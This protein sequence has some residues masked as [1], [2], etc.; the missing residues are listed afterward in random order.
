MPSIL[1]EL[2][3]VLYCKTLVHRKGEQLLIENLLQMIS[4][5]AHCNTKGAQM[6]L[7]SHKTCDHYI[8]FSKLYASS[9]L[10]EK[11]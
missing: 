10:F 3:Q 7:F 11:L 5:L 1:E 6:K 2:G 4:G 8:R 9:M